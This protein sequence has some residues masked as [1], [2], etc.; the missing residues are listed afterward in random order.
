MDIGTAKLTA[1]RAGR[2]PAPPARRLAGHRTAASAVYQRLCRGVLD[3]LLGRADRRCWSAAPG[4]TCGRCSTTCEFPGTDPAV[5]ARLEAAS[6]PSRRRARCTRGWP[7]ST[8]PRRERMEPTQRPPD[9]ARAGGRRADRRRCPGRSRPTT[10]S[11]TTVQVGLDRDDLAE[12]VAV[13]VDRMWAPGLVEEVAGLADAGLRDGV[14]AGRALG[15]AQALGAARR[16]ADEVQAQERP[17][18]PPAGSSAASAAGSAA[19]PG[20]AGWTGTGPSWRR[21]SRW[22]PA[23]PGHRVITSGHPGCCQDHL[24]TADGRREL[25]P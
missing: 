25:R 2:R 3:D 10:A 19:T 12:R 14:T 17:S 23:D 22:S 9:R 20:C 15:Y 4:C 11:T 6:L 8:R 5:R 18:S 1:R 13:R 21:H 7:R 16:P 24:P